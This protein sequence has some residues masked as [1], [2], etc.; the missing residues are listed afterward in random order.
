MNTQMQPIY[1]YMATQLKY[2]QWQ[3]EK[4]SLRPWLLKSPQNMS[5]ENEFVSTFGRDMKIITTHR[6]PKSIVASLVKLAESFRALFSETQSEKS[7]HRLGQSM[8]AGFATIINTHMAWRDANPDMEI[9]DLSFHDVRS[10][11]DEVLRQVYD[12]LDIELTPAVEEKVAVWERKSDAKH[13]S[14]KY[15]LEQ[16]GLTE[17]EVDEVFKPYT[18]RFSRY[19]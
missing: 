10:N 11:T 2:L 6:D 1:D 7:L 14:H 16:F 5:Y 9:L 15:S 3:F 19:I 13:Q 12:Y 4:D 17:E 18:E 8:L